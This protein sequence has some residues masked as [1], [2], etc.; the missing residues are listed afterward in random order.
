MTNFDPT[1]VVIRFDKT[2]DPDER[3]ILVDD[4]QRFGISSRTGLALGDRASAG[5][6]GPTVVITV[7]EGVGADAAINLTLLALR[8]RDWLADQAVSASMELE[9]GGTGAVAVIATYDSDVAIDRLPRA[10]SLADGAEP[11]AWD[12]AGWTEPSTRSS[13]SGVSRGDAIR[14]LALDTEWFSAHGGLSTINRQLC[15]ALAA[16]GADVYCVVPKATRDETDHAEMVNV[17]LLSSVALPGGVGRDVLMRRPPLPDGVQPDLIIGHGRITGPHAKS[18]S[19]DHFPSAARVHIVHTSSDEIEW[20]RSDLQNAGVTAERNSMIDVDLAADATL[21]LGIGPRLADLVDLELSVFEHKPSRGRIDPGFDVAQDVDRQPPPGRRR[22]IMIMGR[23]DDW[24]VKGVDF[25]AKAIADAMDLL[26]ADAAEIELLLRGVPPE[27]H[28]QMR[29]LVLAWAGNPALRVTPRSYTT[30]DELIRRD[31]RRATLVVM[32]SKAEGFGLAGLEAI[33][34]GT[35]VLISAKSGL[36][37][38]L[39]EC[40]PKS[41]ADRIVLPIDADAQ[42]RRKWTAAILRVLA[43][44]EA[45]FRNAATVRR[46]M[47]AERTWAHAAVALL[48]GV[49]TAHGP[50]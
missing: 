25:A 28:A 21:T 48:D 41:D 19:E 50:S 35:P 13:A 36:G 38:L 39:R 12:G 14:V 7:N 10:L 22:Q 26:P 37:M 47:A 27:E 43:D 40:L 16:A 23:L 3:A 49:R 8:A 30:D 42:D 18:I 44:P 20:Q 9:L 2:V 11:I 6:A 29:A 46:L 17:T 34:A 45:S 15:I 4:L 1:H 24:G 5:G 32:P 31:L 33:V